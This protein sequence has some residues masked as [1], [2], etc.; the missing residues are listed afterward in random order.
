MAKKRNTMTLSAFLAEGSFWM[1]KS[2]HK[3]WD[4][5]PASRGQV[6]GKDQSSRH[7][8]SIT[9]VAR[10]SCPGT[11]GFYITEKFFHTTM[12]IFTGPSRDPDMKYSKKFS[13]RVPYFENNL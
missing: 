4:R 8:L 1:D 7:R 3:R 12:S 13:R 11:L 6:T 9:L 5:K 2:I 10:I